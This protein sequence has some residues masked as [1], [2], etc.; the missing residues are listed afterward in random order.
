MTG[1]G[2]VNFVEDG[3]RFDLSAFSLIETDLCR[4][5]SDSPTP[6]PAE[7]CGIFSL[8]SFPFCCFGGFGD[9]AFWR[10][11]I[12]ADVE[13]TFF[14]VWRIIGAE[15]YRLFNFAWDSACAVPETKAVSF[16]RLTPAETARLLS[17]SETSACF[18]RSRSSCSAIK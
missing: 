7:V 4:R 14:M 9:I 12:E 1:V 5:T 16:K 6:L 10:F 2:K 15:L 11:F 8:F 18:L 13:L 17:I 3:I